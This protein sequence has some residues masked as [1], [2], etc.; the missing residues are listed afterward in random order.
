[1]AGLI[2]VRSIRD[3][4]TYRNG[5]CVCRVVWAPQ[6]MARSRLS[7]FASSSVW[8]GGFFVSSTWT[9]II[10]PSYSGLAD[11]AHD[12]LCSGHTHSY[13]LG[14][15]Y[16]RET[17]DARRLINSR[18]FRMAQFWEGDQGF[19]DN[20]VSSTQAMDRI[21]F[22]STAGPDGHVVG[23]YRVISTSLVPADGRFGVVWAAALRIL[24]L[25]ANTPI[26]AGGTSFL[27]G[28]VCCLEG[29]QLRWPRSLPLG[30]HGDRSFWLR[31]GSGGE[32]CLMIVSFGDLSCCSLY[33][34]SIVG[35][36][37]QG[38]GQDLA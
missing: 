31:A 36:S 11:W 23:S 10:T 15:G 16:R 33:V 24:V 21:F 22:I 30:E 35:L 25:S 9:L 20:I 18:R 1:M 32:A 27:V 4:V 19:G 26:V 3:A 6:G 12:L 14:I 8:K 37:S 13:E 5:T 29:V 38:R 7:R 17:E 2:Q 28:M 34:I